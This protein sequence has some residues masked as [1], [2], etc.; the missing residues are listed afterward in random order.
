[1]PSLMKYACLFFAALW[2][3]ACSVSKSYQHQGETEIRQIMA[4]Q[5]AAW[6]R[7]D[8][9]AFMNGYWES[10][11]LK[12]IGSRGLTYG[13]HNT[14]ENYKKSYPNP[15]IMGQLTFHLI[16][17]SVLDKTNAHVIGRYDLKR[18]MG[19]ASGH[20]TLFW[21]KIGGKWVIIADHSS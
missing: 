21:K 9:P 6:N 19:D 20:F 4:R 7:G 12:F 14:L 18:E 1:M 17:V 8:I 5:Q 15:A 10:D 16:E 13:W 11:S 3:T 2:L